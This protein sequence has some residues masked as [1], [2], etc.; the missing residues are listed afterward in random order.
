MTTIAEVM[1]RSDSTKKYEA[2][3]VHVVADKDNDE[4]QPPAL[5]ELELRGVGHPNVRVQTLNLQ[6]NHV[7]HLPEGTEIGSRNGESVTVV[8]EPKARKGGHAT[9]FLNEGRA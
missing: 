6:G 8:L 7:A 9:I 1:D 4:L 5:Y 3:R 2:D